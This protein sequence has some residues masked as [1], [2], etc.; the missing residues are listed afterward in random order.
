MTRPTREAARRALASVAPLCATTTRHFPLAGGVLALADRDG[1]IDALAFGHADLERAVPMTAPRLFEIGSISKLFTSLVID[2]LIES[3]RLA[4]EDPVGPLLAWAGLSPSI[5]R[6]RV[7]ELLTHTAGLPLGSDGLADDAGELWASRETVAADVDPP[8]FH[9]SNL[10]YLVLGEVARTL[11]G[12][13]LPELVADWLLGPLGMET[14]VAE[15]AWGTRESL[16][17]GYAPARPDRPWVPGDPIAPATYFETDSAAGNVAAS[18]IDMAALV[19]ALLR[20]AAG[21]A[22]GAI[23]PATFARV[24]TT[25]APTGEPTHTPVGTLPVTMSRYGLGLNV[26]RIGGNL[27]VTHGGGMVGHSTFLLVDCTLG[28]GVVVLTNA[29]GDTLASHLLARAA[30][31][32]LVAEATG[33]PS[34]LPDLDPAVRTTL[35]GAGALVS[36]TGE[37]L[38]IVAG[39]EGARV[40]YRGREGS[41]YRTATGRFVSDH[42]ALRPF[43]LDRSAEGT[44]THGPTTF[45]PPGSPLP[46]AAG[47]A[48]TP[49]LVGHYRSY[50]PWYPEFRV[51]ARAGRLYLNAP[52]GV[53]APDEEV[54]LVEVAPGTYRI[55]EDPWLAERLVEGPVRDG[56]VVAVV[57]DGLRYSRVFSA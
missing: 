5:A 2:R 17:T 46:P 4:G 6:A 40:R 51:V 49:A 14:A 53:E 25:L 15:I 57:R 27:C 39:D 29:N 8:R 31:A 22:G 42:P 55:G 21:E 47:R 1:L 44:W 16:A 9:Y 12:R 26:E 36:D 37:P 18:A 52:G 23:S 50:S 19:A 11:T 45:S 54:A 33:T 41:L 48:T 28:L 10:G 43:H 34:A 38:E 24:T 32:Q 13:R 7:V 30:H 3:G 56:E 35:E 20:A